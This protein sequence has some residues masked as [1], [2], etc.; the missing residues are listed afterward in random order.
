M[1][2]CVSL[3]LVCEAEDSP[4]GEEGLRV[5]AVDDLEVLGALGGA[6]KRRELQP[7]Q[8]IFFLSIGSVAYYGILLNKK[9]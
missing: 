4:S 2:P 9:M 1:Y 8:I 7:Q 3:Y 6:Q 5:G